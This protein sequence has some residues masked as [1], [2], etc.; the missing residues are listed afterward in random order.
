MLISLFIEVDNEFVEL[1]IVQNHFLLHQC[2]L[3]QGH[4]QQDHIESI[5]LAHGETS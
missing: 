4:R 2:S 3:I 1:V 5:L